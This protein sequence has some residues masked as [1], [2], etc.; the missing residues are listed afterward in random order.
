MPFCDRAHTLPE[1]R[2]Q[3]E[4]FTLGFFQAAEVDYPR[5]RPSIA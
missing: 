5:A 2:L 1:V 4:F 3:V